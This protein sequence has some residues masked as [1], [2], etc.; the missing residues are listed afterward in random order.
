MSCPG[1]SGRNY[2]FSMQSLVKSFEVTE[3]PGV[4]MDFAANAMLS[5]A[6][7]PTA[8]NADF[9]TSDLLYCT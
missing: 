8:E 5:A 6:L 9:S 2:I 4:A 1:I 7:T 3:L